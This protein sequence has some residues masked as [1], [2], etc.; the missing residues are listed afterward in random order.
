MQAKVNA[1]F[2]RGSPFGTYH[3]VVLTLS[4]TSN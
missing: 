2:S 4:S 3:R 1:T